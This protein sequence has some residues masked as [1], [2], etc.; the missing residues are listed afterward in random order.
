MRDLNTRLRPG[1]SWSILKYALAAYYG[2]WKKAIAAE[3]RNCLFQQQMSHEM[4][5]A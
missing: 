2:A 5:V 3:V 1:N 4:W